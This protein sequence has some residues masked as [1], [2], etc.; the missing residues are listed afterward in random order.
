M[1]DYLL[2]LVFYA[3]TA[4]DIDGGETMTATFISIILKFRSRR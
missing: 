3:V 1:S 4:P 2:R